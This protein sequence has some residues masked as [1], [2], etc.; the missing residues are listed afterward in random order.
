MVTAVVSGHRDAGFLIDEVC[1]GVQHGG[2]H[3]ASDLSCGR[4][5]WIL[6][7]GVTFPPWPPEPANL[8]RYLLESAHFET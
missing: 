6:S 3:V 1:A 5:Y 8:L 4:P 2:A 7:T